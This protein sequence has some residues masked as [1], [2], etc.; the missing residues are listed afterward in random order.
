ME[1]SSFL[2]INSFIIGDIFIISGLVPRIIDAVI[3][4]LLSKSSRQFFEQYSHEPY[5][6]VARFINKYLGMPE[7]RRAEFEAKKNGGIKALKVMESQL[8]RTLYLAGDH[9]T[10]ADISLYAYTHVAHEGGFNLSKFPRINAWMT[11]I[12]QHPRHVTMQH[13]MK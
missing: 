8:T 6:A 1:K 7:S 10:T 12:Q 2:N 3:L 13:F 5:I 9:Y 11:R 4:Y